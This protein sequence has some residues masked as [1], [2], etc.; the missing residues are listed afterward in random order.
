MQDKSRNNFI[1]IAKAI[2]IILMVAGHSGCPAIMN[3]FLYIFHMP[4]FFVCSGYFFYEITDI[5]SYFIF[6]KRKIAKLYL[7]YIKWSILFLVLHNSFYYLHISPISPYNT[8]RYFKQFVKTILMS[9]YELLIRPFWFLKALL[10]SSIIIATLSLLRNIFCHRISHEIFIFFILLFSIICKYYKIDI[11]VL[12]NISI[13][14]FSIVYIY[15][16]FLYHKYEKYIQPRITITIS[17]FLITLLGSM[18]FVGDI[19]MR[20]TTTYSILPFLLFSIAGIIMT[21]CISKRMNSWFKSNNYLYYIGNHTM[22]ILVLNL[23]SLKIGSLCKILYFH[24][25]IESLASH[26][27]IYEHNYSFW[28]IYTIIGVIVPLYLEI[29][30]H[31]LFNIVKFFF[32][33][34]AS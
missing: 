2:G 8:V 29:S 1:S 30:Y 20:Y 26:P 18:F 16:G 34:F 5:N 6:L 15:I 4:L 32:K 14:S 19:D 22:P 21:L 27:I 17:T 9:D 13:I 33:R 11:P 3:R 31:Y 12:G 10:F 7:P 24:M 25:P 28:L 23:L